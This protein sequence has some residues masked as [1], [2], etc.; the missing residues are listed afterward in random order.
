[1]KLGQYILHSVQNKPGKLNCS[2]AALHFLSSLHTFLQ[3]KG[4]LDLVSLI[5]QVSKGFGALRHA[6]ISLIKPLSLYESVEEIHIHPL[7]WPALAIDYSLTVIT[8]N[9]LD[10]A[11][12]CRISIFQTAWLV[13]TLLFLIPLYGAVN[14]ASLKGRA[15]T[16]LLNFFKKKNRSQSFP[17]P[18]CPHSPQF[19]NFTI[20]LNPSSFLSVPHTHTNT[21]R[22]TVISCP[23]FLLCQAST[24]AYFHV[25]TPSPVLPPPTHERCLTQ[26]FSTWLIATSVGVAVR[27]V[28]GKRSKDS[29]IGNGCFFHGWPCNHSC[30][31]LLRLNHLLLYWA[32]WEFLLWGALR[33]GHAFRATCP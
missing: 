27:G 18:H 11:S 8:R 6:A 31:P 1:M 33:L 7:H 28:E 3:Q 16:Y 20:Y 9:P 21:V 13:S 30:T 17:P 24:D 26:A 12:C 15:D 2:A 19:T 5:W 23:R 32:H 14:Q 10:G 22:M 25:Q 29:Q 4:E